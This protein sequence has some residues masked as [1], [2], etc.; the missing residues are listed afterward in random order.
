MKK[1]TFKLSDVNLRTI[2]GVEKFLEEY[3]INA[4]NE[5]GWTNDGWTALILASSNGHLEA[6][7][8]LIEHRAN[9]NAKDDR[10]WTA[11]MY[12]VDVCFT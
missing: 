2:E 5:Y 12:C 1:T 8:Y 3:D 11:L 6:V 9:V 7:K 10:G 4:R